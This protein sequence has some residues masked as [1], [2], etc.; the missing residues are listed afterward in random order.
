MAT[1]N[2]CGVN[3]EYDCSSSPLD[4]LQSYA[5]LYWKYLKRGFNPE[6]IR[7]NIRDTNKKL[8]SLIEHLRSC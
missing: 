4:K 5:K 1:K 6:V 8:D 2:I 7:D 3:V